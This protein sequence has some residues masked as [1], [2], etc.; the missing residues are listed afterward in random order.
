[1]K[2]EKNYRV[3]PVAHSCVFK[4]DNTFS[5]NLFLVDLGLFMVNTVSH[6]STVWLCN[7]RQ[8]PFEKLF[9]IVL[10][11]E[12][13]AQKSGNS[14]TVKRLLY[15]AFVLYTKENLGCKACD[16]RLHAGVSKQTH[17]CCYSSQKSYVT[18]QT[19]LFERKTSNI[20]H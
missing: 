2:N 19:A 14:A 4:A 11:E 10:S 12:L 9:L 6:M 17:D 7:G 18:H 1:M 13:L 3:F 5:Q 16:F 15:V 8:A 20:N